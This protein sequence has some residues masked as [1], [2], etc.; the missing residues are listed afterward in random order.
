MDLFPSFGNR[1]RCC[2]TLELV[3][4]LVQTGMLSGRVVGGLAQLIERIDKGQH[5]AGTVGPQ[6]VPKLDAAPIEFEDRGRV[7]GDHTATGGRALRETS[8]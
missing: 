1:P 8:P 3:G 5:G 2:S 6:L 4:Q 7:V